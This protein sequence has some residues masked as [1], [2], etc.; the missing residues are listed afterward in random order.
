MAKIT[1]IEQNGTLT[2]Q[3]GEFFKMNVTLD[4]GKSGEVLAKTQD[5]WKVGDEVEAELTTTQYGNKLKLSKPQQGGYSGKGGFSPEKEKR[6]TFLS[7]LSS[8]ASFHAQSSV[9]PE[10][11]IETAKK[12]AN[13]AFSLDKPQAQPAKQAPPKQQPPIE[14]Y[15]A[16][17]NDLPF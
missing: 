16:D 9:T 8:A 17:D 11:V 12:F 15:A 7:C 4:D 14:A 3:S 2:L 13:A 1:Q 5:R 6:I 10:Q